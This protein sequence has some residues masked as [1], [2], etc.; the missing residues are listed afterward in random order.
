[1]KGH[2][3]IFLRTPYV[4]EGFVMGS[5]DRI[6]VCVKNIE[7]IDGQ[8]L[9]PCSDIKAFYGLSVIAIMIDNRYGFGFTISVCI[10][11]EIIVIK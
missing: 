6:K 5:M 11:R 2:P 10:D 7:I 1:M 9:I 8:Y 3:V 4:E